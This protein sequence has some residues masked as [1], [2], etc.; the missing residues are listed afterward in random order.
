[1]N[2]RFGPSYRWK[3]QIVSCLLCFTPAFTVH[4]IF[5]FGFESYAIIST[6]LFWLTYHVY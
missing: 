4:A 5:T 1:M 6:G 2:R 3:A